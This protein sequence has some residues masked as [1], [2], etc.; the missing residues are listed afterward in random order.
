MGSTGF[1]GDETLGESSFTSFD[2]DYNHIDEP[3]DDEEGEED[4]QNQDTFEYREG[5]EV[6]EEEGNQQPKIRKFNFSCSKF[7]LVNNM[8][9]L[10]QNMKTL[11]KTKT[12]TLMRQLTRAGCSSWLTRR[13]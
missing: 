1:F 7:V 11:M 5:E 12:W 3:D 9:F 8:Q 6:E 10:L 2:G 4:Y 13:C